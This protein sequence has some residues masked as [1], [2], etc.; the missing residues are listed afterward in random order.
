MNDLLGQA[1]RQ[2]AARDYRATE[3]VCRT[4]IGADPHHFDALHLLGVVLTL[5][6]RTADG[7]TVP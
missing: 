5:Q 1:A 2:Y 6:E 4:I 3:T 7:E